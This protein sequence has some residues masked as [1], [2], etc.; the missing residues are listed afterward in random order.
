MFGW[1][2]AGSCGK[3][4]DSSASVALLSVE[5]RRLKEDL[6]KIF[7]NDFPPLLDDELQLSREAK[8]ALEQLEETIKWDEQK[9]K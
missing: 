3:K 8:Y 2:V 4:T 6:Q 5:D 1:T 7:T 9:K